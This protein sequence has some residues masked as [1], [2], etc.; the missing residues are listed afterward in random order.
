[1]HWLDI[2]VILFLILV[3]VGGVKDGA[4]KAGFSLVAL[5]IA[6]PVAGASY[7]LITGWLSFFPGENWENFMGFFIT[8]GIISAIM[9]LIFMIP[10]KI[11]KKIWRKGCV[12]R[13]LGGLL[14][15]LNSFIG[16]TVFTLVLLA[17]PIIGWL[18]DIVS[19]SAI[20]MW[21]AESWGF[22]AAMLPEAL[23]HA[24]QM[25]NLIGG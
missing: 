15:L 13:L 18:A 7:Q 16:L 24:P 20:L 5:I 23:R 21:L 25:L 2:L 8:L 12:F 9:G 6:I 11:V 19:K 22:V 3:L 17:Y 4:I 1:M 14:N 10:R